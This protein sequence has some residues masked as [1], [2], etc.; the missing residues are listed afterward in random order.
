MIKDVLID[1]EVWHKVIHW[2][3]SWCLLFVLSATGGRADWVRLHSEH[4][5]TSISILPFSMNT[6]FH[7]QVIKTSLNI[8]IK[9]IN[10]IL[11]NFWLWLLFPYPW[12]T[13]ISLSP[14]DTVCG[15]KNVSIH[16]EVWYEVI[17]WV[18]EWGSLFVLSATGGRADWV[19]SELEVVL[20]HWDSFFVSFCL[21]H[22]V[23]FGGGG[24]GGNLGFFRE[25]FGVVGSVFWGSLRLS[26]RRVGSDSWH[27]DPLTVFLNWSP[28]FTNRF[29]SCGDGFFGPL[30]VLINSKVW[31]CISSWVNWRCFHIE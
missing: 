5:V 17:D 14:C 7:L 28:F 26:V 25:S 27:V 29:L 15:F 21:S 23:S 11:S 8:N 10:L 4:N 22:G 9:R 12:V 2:V 13:S 3:T 30:D 20:V 24:V 6:F 19:G 18:G 16:S 1:A 31:N